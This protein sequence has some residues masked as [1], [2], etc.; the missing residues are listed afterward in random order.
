MATHIRKDSINQVSQI[1]VHRW[2]VEQVTI[3]LT[4]NRLTQF[5]ELFEGLLRNIRYFLIS[6]KKKKKKKKKKK[7]TISNKSK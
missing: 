6:L 5:I 2:N 7:N 3:W 1:P 4:E